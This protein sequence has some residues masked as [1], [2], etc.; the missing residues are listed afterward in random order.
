MKNKI[1]AIVSVISLLLFLLPNASAQNDDNNETP[2]IVVTKYKS[3]ESEKF[4]WDT[5]NKYSP[6][7]YITAG[8]MGYFWRESNFRSDAV[9][10]WATSQKGYGKDFCKDFT[11][12][13]DAGLRD[14]S[15]K[16]YFIE[17][18]QNKFGGYGLGQWRSTNY[19]DEFYDFAQE[20]NTSISDAEM[21]C[22]FIIWSLENQ[23]PEL[24]EKII[25]KKN[26]EKIGKL[27]AVYYDGT[28]IGKDYIGYKAQK[29]Y[30]KYH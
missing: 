21:Q 1:I 29:F 18:C 12:K 22:A 8:I 14:A 30:D 13:V 6:N 24:W 7:D 9:A 5:L 27:I 11:T 26:A 15:T 23:Q 10:G 2:I 17:K 20:W 3:K 25:H 4:L 28:Q 16:D 19:L